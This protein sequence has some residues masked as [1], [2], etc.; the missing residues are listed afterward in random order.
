MHRYRRHWRHRRHPHRRC[1]HRHPNPH[2]H[3]DY[4]LTSVT[5][6]IAAGILGAQH[7]VRD[8]SV[9]S[10]ALRVRDHLM[11]M[12]ISL[13]KGGGR[14]WEILVEDKIH[15]NVDLQEGTA[16]GTTRW[17]GSPTWAGKEYARNLELSKLCFSFIPLKKAFFMQAG[18][19]VMIII[20]INM[21]T[22]DSWHPLVI[23]SSGV[24]RQT[25]RSDVRVGRPVELQHG[26]DGNCIIMT[27]IT[28]IMV[29]VI[30][31]EKEV[32]I[33]GWVL[34]MM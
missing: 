22:C 6:S 23:I 25:G 19:P 17:C 14:N 28:M 8:S 29:M 9:R 5:S 4:D 10:V 3:Q 20:I 32:W 1:H 13:L 21:L 16:G 30:L 31:Q 15:L 26:D 18:W 33:W 2:H 11:V 24:L 7:V 34:M 12:V 27:M